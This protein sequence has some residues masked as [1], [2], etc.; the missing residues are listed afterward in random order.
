MAC[1]RQHVVGKHLPR[2]FASWFEML[3]VAR[4]ESFNVLLKQREMIMKCRDHEAL[5][6]MVIER[7]WYL[8]SSTAEVTEEDI[9]LFNHYFTSEIV[10]KTLTI[11][12][13]NCTAALIHWRLI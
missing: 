13:L 12:P 7:N 4:M 3:L 10:V 5:L 8:E 1:L 11:K 6:Q 2:S 9:S